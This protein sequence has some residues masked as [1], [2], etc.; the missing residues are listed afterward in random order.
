[1][2]INKIFKKIEQESI[3]KGIYFPGPESVKITLTLS[4]K[5][6]KEFLSN[7]ADT[8]N[9]NNYYWELINDN[10]LILTYFNYEK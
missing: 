7:I 3:N 2:L 1:M 4:N 10:E 5:E 9:H 6:K 8:L